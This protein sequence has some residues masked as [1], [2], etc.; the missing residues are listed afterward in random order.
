[1][2]V[3]LESERLYLRPWELADAES[4][5]SGW[6]NDPEVTR[7]LTWNPHSSVDVTKAIIEKWISEYGD[8]KRLNFAITRKEDGALIGGIGGLVVGSILGAAI[9]GDE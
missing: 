6:A 7:Y 9:L 1:M 8:P 2:K 5:F 4:M 3:A